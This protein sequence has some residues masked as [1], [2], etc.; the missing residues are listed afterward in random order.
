[1]T[2]SRR[3]SQTTQAVLELIRSHL[4][5]TIQQVR[6]RLDLDRRRVSEILS[7]LTERGYAHKIAKATYA[8]TCP[9][10]DRF[11]PRRLRRRVQCRPGPLPHHPAG[12][13]EIN[14]H[15]HRDKKGRIPVNETSA[16]RATRAAPGA[17]S[18]CVSSSTRYPT[19]GLFSPGPERRIYER[20]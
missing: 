11:E 16:S 9:P 10:D 2:K 15:R 12:V 3:H 8:P 6:Q 13:H 17:P 1:M 4:S 19:P 5:T 20:I 18:G 14:H 7:R